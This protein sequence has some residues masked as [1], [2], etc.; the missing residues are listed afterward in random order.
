MQF[1]REYGLDRWLWAWWVRQAL[2]LKELLSGT[3]G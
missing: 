3:C 2:G 1:D